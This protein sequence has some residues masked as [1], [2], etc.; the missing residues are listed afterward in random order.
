MKRRLLSMFVVIC[1]MFTMLPV[2][3]IAD[4]AHTGIDNKEE[5]IAVKPLEETEKIVPIGTPIEDLK[6]PE[7]LKVIVRANLVANEAETKNEEDSGST[8]EDMV[9][10][11]WSDATTSSAIDIE[12]TKDIEVEWISEPAYD[13]NTEGEYVFKPVIEGYVISSKLPEIKVKVGAAAA[14]SMLLMTPSSITV[15]NESEWQQA[16][17]DVEDGGT[18][19]LG[20]Y[21]NPRTSIIINDDSNKDI[22]IDLNGKWIF[23]YVEG[24]FIQ[25]MTEGTLTI[26]DNNGDGILRNQSGSTIEINSGGTL[27][28]DGAK[29]EGAKDCAIKNESSTVNLWGGSIISTQ[30]NVD[31]IK[32]TG[33]GVININGGRI[34]T[35]RYGITNSESTGTLNIFGGASTIRGSTLALYNIKPNFGDMLVTVDTDFYGAYPAYYNEENISS[36]K[37]LLFEPDLGDVAQIG[38]VTYSTLQA[39]IIEASDNDTITLLTDINLNGTVTIPNATSKNYT[40]D[41]NGKKLYYSGAPIRHSGNGILTIDD[42]SGGSGEIKVDSTSYFGVLLLSS[43][44]SITVAGGTIIGGNSGIYSESRTG[45]V[46]VT[47]GKILVQ[48]SGG[49]AIDNTNNGSVNVSGGEVIGGFYGIYNYGSQDVTPAV[50]VSGGLI[51]GTSSGIYYNNTKG[52][53][54]TVSG[55]SIIKGQSSYAIG[56]NVNLILLEAKV[57]KASTNFDGSLPVAFSRK[58]IRTYKYLEFG[59]APPDATPPTGTISVNNNNLFSTFLNT[60]TFSGFYKSYAYVKITGDDADSGVKKLEY[61]KSGIRYSTEEEVKVLSGW[62]T[63]AQDEMFYINPSWKGYIYARI[64]DYFNNMTVIR[65]DGV[66]VYKDSAVN[67]SSISFTKGST[68]DISVPVTLNSNSINKI[69]NGTSTLSASDYTV[70]GGNIIFK[71]NYLN[72]LEE[73]SEAYPLVVHYNPQG[74][75]YPVSPLSGSVAPNTSTISLTVLMPPLEITTTPLPNGT[76]GAAYSQTLHTTNNIPVIWSIESGTLPT[77]LVL[78][79]MDGAISGIPLEAGTFNFTV[80]AINGAQSDTQEFSITI[81]PPLPNI[82]TGVAVINNIMPRIG[83]TLTGSLEGGNNT[84][85]LNYTWRSGTTIVGTG[86]SYEVTRLDLGKSITLEITSSKEIGTITSEETVAVRKKAALPTPKAPELTLKTHD[87]VTLTANEDYEF[88]KDGVTWQ[89]DHVFNGLLPNTTYSFYQRV[90]ETDDTESSE[91]SSPLVVTTYAEEVL[92]NPLT[93]TAIISNNT[94]RIGDLLTGLLEGGNN[95]GTLSYTWKA[96]SLTLG[97]GPSYEVTASNLG[98]T[99]VLEITSSKETGT[100]TSAATAAVL[101]KAPPTPPKAPSLSSKTHNTVTLTTNKD[102]EFSKDGVTWQTSPVF[103]SLTPSTSYIFYQRVAETDDTEASAKSQGLTVT[104]ESNNNS[105]G[106]SGGGSGSS[107]GNG[108]SSSGNSNPVITAPPTTDKPDLPEVDNPDSSEMTDVI[109]HWA[110][111]DIEFVVRKGLLNGTDTHTFSPNTHM[112]RGM[113]ATALGR[114]AKADVSSYKESSFID[115][116]KDAYYIGYIEWASKN[117]IVKGVGNGEFAPDETI[118]R[119]QVAVMMYSYAKAMG[120][121]LPQIY[122]ENTFVDSDKISTYAKEAVKFM[123]MAGI[124]NGK[125]GNLFDP[126]ATATRAEVSAVLSR[127]VKLIDIQMKSE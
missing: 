8:K 33:T 97:T 31:G 3:L 7:A 67:T 127:F 80:K 85:I 28:I 21:M 9:V 60:A 27:T 5:I 49:A 87:S 4:E 89:K 58:N 105:G 115:V 77:G 69:M 72:T 52:G 19:V 14:K 91:K 81:S 99:I 75:E 125:N 109:A 32:N 121:T 37:S 6:L 40:L 117:N 55:P 43:S 66:V 102:Y 22:I 54:V 12:I 11:D 62:T 113:F 107:S 103:S 82:L 112:T 101:K 68:T 59:S 24:P 57:V 123:Q 93:G 51:S 122:E 114:L 92:P 29:I 84:G 42:S 100:V 126:Q 90:A 64:T 88:S 47:G 116:T 15:N 61:L 96:G 70:L 44:G 2:S 98:K 35:Y 20:Q 94:P 56:S 108:G 13:M 71:A 34:S 50:N 26:V 30:S 53:N 16:I 110:K 118:T 23:P 36:Y 46:N 25:H 17:I 38:S 119:E 111:D 106:G 120:I 39:A 95:T 10:R 48:D 86:P 73:R 65:S 76:V 104:T 79:T 45:A 1:M 18:I 74:V 41:L 124:I 78:N 83:D 63:V